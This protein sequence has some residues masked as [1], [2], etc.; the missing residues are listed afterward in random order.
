MIKI[1]KIFI[2]NIFTKSL[3]KIKKKTLKY[4]KKNLNN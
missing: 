4:Q 2:D 1:L 3:K